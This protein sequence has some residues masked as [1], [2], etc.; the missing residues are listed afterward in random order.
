MIKK[1]APLV[2]AAAIGFAAGSISS[3]NGKYAL[4]KEAGKEYLCK[5]ATK[6][7]EQITADFQLGSLEYRLDGIKKQVIGLGAV[8]NVQQYQRQ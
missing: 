4:K 3:C 7:C 5:K 1:L 8:E 2:L 6:Q